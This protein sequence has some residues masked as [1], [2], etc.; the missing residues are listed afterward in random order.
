MLEDLLEPYLSMMKVFLMLIVTEKGDSDRE[1]FK[2][3][4]LIILRMKS[5]VSKASVQKFYCLS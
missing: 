3:D 4:F 2:F 1:K 5:L